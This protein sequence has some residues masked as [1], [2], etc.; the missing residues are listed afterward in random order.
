MH[1]SDSRKRVN[2]SIRQRD[3]SWARSLCPT[4][5]LG[6]NWSISL[7]LNFNHDWQNFVELICSF[8][9]LRRPRSPPKFNQFFFLLPEVLHNISLQSIDNFWVMLVTLTAKHTA[10]S[11]LPKH[12]LLCQGYVLIQNYNVMFI[13]NYQ[14]LYVPRPT[15]TSWSTLWHIYGF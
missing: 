10:K 13:V 12:N 11:T 4:Q 7:K 6:S 2:F 14:I 5:N 3:L 9:H 1:S 15:S 8:T